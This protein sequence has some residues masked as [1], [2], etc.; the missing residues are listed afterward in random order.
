LTSNHTIEQIEQIL[1]NFPCQFIFDGAM[2]KQCEEFIDSYVPELLQWIIK[3]ETPTI[4]CTQI[5]LCP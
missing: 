5:G 4:F 3:N 2:E 1:H